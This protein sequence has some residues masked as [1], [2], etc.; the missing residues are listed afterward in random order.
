MLFKPG[1]TR[2]DV[3]EGSRCTGPGD[4]N[5]KHELCSIL[6][7]N[8]RAPGEF[9]RAFEQKS[10]YGLP[11]LRMMHETNDTQTH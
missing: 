1:A 8:R 10:T 2:P 6:T 9:S 4:K 11:T 7:P 5:M 3:K